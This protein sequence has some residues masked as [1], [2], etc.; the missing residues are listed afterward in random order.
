MKNVPFEWETQN[1][2][3]VWDVLDPVKANH[4]NN[5][6][7]KNKDFGYLDVKKEILANSVSVQ[8]ETAVNTFK[9]WSQSRK[10]GPLH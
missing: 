2:L 7:P 9:A 10:N 8:I 6:N 5:I 3:T 4:A 1:D